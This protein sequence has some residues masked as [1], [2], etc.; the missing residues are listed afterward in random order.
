MIKELIFH[1]FY[2]KLASLFYLLWKILIP[3][4]H[5]IIINYTYCLCV[6]ENSNNNVT[7]TAESSL[8]FFWSALSLVYIPLGLCSQNT[9]FQSS[10]KNY[11]SLW[12]VPPSDAWVPLIGIT[13]ITSKTPPTKELFIFS[14]STHRNVCWTG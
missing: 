1:I 10:L 5:N 14:D 4:N 2:F 13:Q 8:K 3:S 11:F 9:A 7:K 12:D 6:C